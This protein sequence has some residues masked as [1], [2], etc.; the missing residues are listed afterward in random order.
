MKSVT[1]TEL[2]TTVTYTYEYKETPKAL[3]KILRESKLL[4]ME[5]QS[6]TRNKDTFTIIMSKIM[7]QEEF[8]KTL[9]AAI[10]DKK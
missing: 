4:D 9:H 1:K 3:P 10:G 2:L 8:I 6:I 5:I 7:S